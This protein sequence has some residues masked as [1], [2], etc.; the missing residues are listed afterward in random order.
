M[1]S[2]RKATCTIIRPFVTGNGISAILV[3]AALVLAIPALAGFF[4]HLVLTE[5]AVILLAIAI[6]I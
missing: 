5:V 1:P 4:W 3:V 2:E 6:L